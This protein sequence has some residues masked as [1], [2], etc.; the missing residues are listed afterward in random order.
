MHIIDTGACAP[1]K[2]CLLLLL[3]M[4]RVWLWPEEL[5]GLATLLYTKWPK[6]CSGNIT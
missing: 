5:G 1:Q 2:R 6:I 3:A 4:S